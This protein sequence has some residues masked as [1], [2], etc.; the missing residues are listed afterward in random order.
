MHQR[1][2]DAP[3]STWL[4]NERGELVEYEIIEPTSG[5]AWEGP[6]GRRPRARLK[7]ETRPAADPRRARR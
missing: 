5:T 3:R 6:R 4:P 7:G 1:D 2:A